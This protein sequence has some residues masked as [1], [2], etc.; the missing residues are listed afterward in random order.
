MCLNTV[1]FLSQSLLGTN[2]ETK[3]LLLRHF[4]QKLSTVRN[5]E[6]I[7]DLQEWDVNKLKPDDTALILRW[8]TPHAKQILMSFVNSCKDVWWIK[9]F[10]SIFIEM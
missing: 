6:S 7:Y 2:A 5:Q 1:K 4:H 3:S 10:L 9:T 8:L